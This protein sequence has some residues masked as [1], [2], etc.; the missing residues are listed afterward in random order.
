MPRNFR[1]ARQVHLES[2]SDPAVESVLAEWSS[3]MKANGFAVARVEE[4]QTWRQRR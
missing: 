2:R 3:C 1:G 4:R